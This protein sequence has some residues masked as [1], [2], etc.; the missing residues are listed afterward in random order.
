MKNYLELL[1]KVLTLGD[2]VSTRGTSCRSLFSQTLRCSL[3][4][5]RLPLLTTKRIR[6]DYVLAELVWFLSGDDCIRD[7]QRHTPIWDPWA[8]SEGFVPSAYGYWWAQG[9]QL[10]KAIE[11]LR[12]DPT[13]RRYVV[14]AWNAHNGP[15]SKLPPCHFAFVL[16]YCPGRGLGLHVTMRSAD[17]PVGV[18]YNLASYG[19]LLLLICH[20]TGLEPGELVISMVDCH[21][22]EN[23]VPFVEQ[24]L[25]REPV[26]GPI[27]EITGPKTLAYY[28]KYACMSDFVLSGYEPA[29]HIPY[30]VYV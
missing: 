12:R 14:S 17:L 9:G 20:L 10:E 15:T 19:T 28:E 24:Q 21:I 16:N 5:G 6:Y 30:P 4:G 1:A 8:D 2:R 7:L 23:Q 13:S 11:G 27:L 25:L 29:A 22:Y 3:Q 26:L 18:P